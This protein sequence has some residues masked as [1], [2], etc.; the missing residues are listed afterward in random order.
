MAE[1]YL[2]NELYRL[3]QRDDLII[4]F[5]QDGFLDGIWFL[6][7][8]QPDNLWISPGFW[9]L[10]GYEPEERVHLASE[11]KRMINTDDHGVLED[12]LKRHYQDQTFSL[13]LVVRFNHLNGSTIWVRCKGFAF[14][15]AKGK[16]IRM[17]LAYND[18]TPIMQGQQWYEENKEL[19]KLNESLRVMADRD[20]LTNLYN[21]RM[22][23]DRFDYLVSLSIRNQSPLSLA[24]FDIDH[25]K[26]INDSYGHLKGDEVLR[27]F[28]RVLEAT[29]R[30][31]D[32]V[33]RTGGEEFCALF[34]DSDEKEGYAATE[35]I[36]QAV[37]K[38]PLAE[39]SITVSCGVT[40]HRP[41]Q[42]DV[43]ATLLT[44]MMDQADQAL[45][46][47]KA[48]GRNCAIHHIDLQ[49]VAEEPDR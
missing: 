27:D 1:H 23:E 11:W 19:K 18:L 7:L 4:D 43:A 41:N 29:Q 48:S 34:P 39:L 31:V 33:A 47:A 37:R 5:L 13:D 21:R 22:F 25:F 40:T 8:K 12:N 42:V 49:I 20:F 2:K 15:D 36:C 6:D 26:Q 14:R 24:I 38:A 9:R 17:L 28:A 30:D 10:L 45:Y 35:R 32:I 3:L 46:A 44:V 16:A